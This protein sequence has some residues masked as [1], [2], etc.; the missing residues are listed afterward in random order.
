[1][2]HDFSANSAFDTLLIWQNHYLWNLKKLGIKR[3]KYYFERH[4][5]YCI[6]N[7]ANENKTTVWVVE[8]RRQM[9]IYTQDTWL[10]KMDL[11]RSCSITLNECQTLTTS[12]LVGGLVT[13]SCKNFVFPISSNDIDCNDKGSFSCSDDVFLTPG[14]K[15]C[16]ND[17]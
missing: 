8:S 2:N 14:E 1:M 7:N 16:T 9:V 10:S 4:I 11:P 12:Q 17:K 13:N 5:L 6:L 15:I 3:K